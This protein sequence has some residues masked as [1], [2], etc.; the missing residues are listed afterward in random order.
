MASGRPVVS[1]KTFGSCMVEDGKTGFLVPIRDVDSLAEKILDLLNDYELTVKMA[2]N[3]REKVEKEY[4]LVKM[5]EKYYKL[6]ESI[7]Y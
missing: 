3:A 1:T 5:I 4:D 7:V 2:L 6:Y